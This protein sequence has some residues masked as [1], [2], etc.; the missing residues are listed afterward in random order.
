MTLHHLRVAARSFRTSPFYSISNVLGLVIGAAAALVVLLFVRH[1]LSYDSFHADADNT[2]KV[3]WNSPFGK[4]KTAP[5]GTAE[6]VAS[7]IPQ[8]TETAFVRDMVGAYFLDGVE[9]LPLEGVVASG[10]S[11]FSMFDFPLLAGDAA[12]ALDG[13][14]KI[15]LTPE[16]ALLLTGEERPLG[17]IVSYRGSNDLEVTGIAEPPPGNTNIPFRAI[18]SDATFQP[19][20]LHPFRF[21]GSHFIKVSAGYSPAQFEATMDGVDLEALLGWSMGDMTLGIHPLTRLHQDDQMF[22]TEASGVMTQVKIFAVVGLFL[23]LIAALNYMNLSMARSMRRMDEVGMRKAL[24]ASTGQLL[25]Q[26]LAETA[27]VTG[28]SV[29]MA[30]QL[31]SV[32]TPF[33]DNV[34]GVGMTMSLTG[35]T[36]MAWTLVALWGA[37]VVG[38]GLYPAVQFARMRTFAGSNK[39]GARIAKPRLRQALVI[40][41]FALSMLM[42]VGTLL[43]GKQLSF[44]E[45]ADVGYD[46]SELLR[47]S[48]PAGVTSDGSSLRDQMMNVPGVE[49]ASLSFGLP[50]EVM[51]S[52]DEREDGT[53]IPIMHLPV[54]EYFI[55]TAGLDVI[56]GSNFSG[57]MERDQQGIIL[58]ETAARHFGVS[59][60]PIGQTVT[61]RTVVGIVKDYHVR[62]FHHAISPLLLRVDPP[63]MNMGKVLVLRVRPESR[64]SVL[65]AASAIWSSVA[66]GQPFQPVV[67]DAAWENFYATEARLGTLT[68]GFSMLALF[69]AVLGLLGL[70]SFAAEQRT[71]EIGIRKVL[72]ASMGNVVV[73]LSREFVVLLVVAFTLAAPVAWMAGNRWLES[74]A[75]RTEMGVTIFAV[76][77]IAVAGVALLTVALRAVSA[78]LADP[79]DSLRSE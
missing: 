52:M 74:F 39:R 69:I 14:G 16:A 27:L 25:R 11:F 64:E 37:L 59:D 4:S 5:W 8:V 49:S 62:S 32:A 63:E 67:A 65:E 3:Y 75:Y 24:G 42:L 61:N 73:L 22:T 20:T 45:S 34:L 78:S 19:E 66:P 31:A 30:Y 71:K 60:D 28:L 9:V 44:S 21:M 36:G 40:G 56:K 18:I 58:N 15:V 13:P 1:E 6:R 17:A 53:R 23:I 76:A 29:A 33:V 43:V 79:V 35:S 51:T 7:H 10:P 54:D 70:V 26:F 77:G 38:A 55:D 46:R 47:L 50:H 12:T 2:Y 41:Q 72:G 57:I 68:R 48:L